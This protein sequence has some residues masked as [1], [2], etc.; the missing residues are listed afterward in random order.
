LNKHRKKR[1]TEC[2]HNTVKVERD[3]LLPQRVRELEA[4][5]EARG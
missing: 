3:A 2:A 1:P 5:L 4:A